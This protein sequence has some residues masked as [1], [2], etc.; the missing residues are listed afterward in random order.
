VKGGLPLAFRVERG[1]LLVKVAQR[2]FQQLAVAW[3]GGMRKLLKDP[4]SSKLKIISLP[5]APTLLWRNLSSC[6]SVLLSGKFDLFFYRFAFPSTGHKSSVPQTP[7]RLG[8]C[9]A[10]PM[11]GS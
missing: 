7:R 10:V 1:N 6:P 2:G 4:V 3:V 9:C 5:K 8:C 11:I